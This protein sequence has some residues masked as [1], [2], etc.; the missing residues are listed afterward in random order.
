MIIE[1]LV[2]IGENKLVLPHS[3]NY[4]LYQTPNQV[5]LFYVTRGTTPNPYQAEIDLIKRHKQ[6]L[7]A[8]M[9]DNINIVGLCAGT[10][11]TESLLLDEGVGQGKTLHYYAIEKNL[12]V[13]VAS[14][15]NLR[16]YHPTLINADMFDVPLPMLKQ[17]PETQN[18]VLFLGYT[19]GN[20]TLE[21]MSRYFDSNLE[22]GDK[23]YVS[24]QIARSREEVQ[25]EIMPGY[26]TPEYEAWLKY[27]LL[28]DGF[29]D[30]DLEYFARISEASGIPV[31][32]LGFELKE[33][34]IDL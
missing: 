24:M 32:E 26:V 21:E 27:G 25:R 33:V 8:A 4:W 1:H 30:K 28:K 9:P 17:N 5:Q 3:Q 12:D 20:F 31:I 15:E 18:H 7:V 6:G 2:G 13:L 11:S 22:K 23:L 29:R 10:S 34:P 19:F 16:Q 14:Q